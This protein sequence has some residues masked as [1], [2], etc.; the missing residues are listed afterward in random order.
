MLVEDNG[1][2]GAVDAE[3]RSAFVNQV[4]DGRSAGHRAVYLRGLLDPPTTAQRAMRASGPEI[5]VLF[6]PVTGAKVLDNWHTIG[7]RSIGNNDFSAEGLFA[8]TEYTVDQADILRPPA[9]S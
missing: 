3:Q 2:P 7:L 8:P 5:R 1:G 9:P 6:V 4:S